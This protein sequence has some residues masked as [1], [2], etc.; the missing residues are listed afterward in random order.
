M[1]YRYFSLLGEDYLLWHFCN[2]KEA[3]FFLDVGA[4]DGVTISNTKS[5]EDQG[6]TGICAEPHPDYFVVCQQVRRR[7]VRAAC[8]SGS[9]PAISLRVDRSVFSRVRIQMRL[10]PRKSS[11][12]TGRAF[13][14]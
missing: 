4:Y 2:F 14:S 6:W 7:A 10:T 9:A 1:R 11:L 5:F 13:A 3:G 12:G 8:V